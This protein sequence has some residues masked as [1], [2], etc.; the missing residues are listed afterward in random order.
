[1]PSRVPTSSDFP[2]YLHLSI[3]PPPASQTPVN[4]LI[5]LHG[6]GDTNL[7]F[8]TLATQLSLPETACLSIQAPTPLPFELGGFHWGDDI[9]FDQTSGKME[10]DTGFKK[11]V[12]VLGKEMIKDGLIGKCGYAAREILI[13]GFGQG[14]MAALGTSM[15]LSQ[16]QTP[17]EELGGII[18]IGGPLPTLPSDHRSN[19]YDSK[20]PKTKNRSPVLI[21]GGSSNTLITSS[22]LTTIRSEFEFVEYRKWNKSGDG[23]PS[24][25][26]EMMPIMHFFS[27]RLRSRRGVP[28][29]SVEIG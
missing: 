6:L 3:I 14:G 2:P 24:N 17:N 10:F 9:A 13:L 16:T 8:K 11:T 20:K 4:I 25:R 29:G 21:L 1:M 23:M 28:E 15:Y 18:S 22:A 19:A 26:E 12:D 27:R 7:P 5:L